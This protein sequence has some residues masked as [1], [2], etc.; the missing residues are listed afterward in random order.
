M[1]P[2]STTADWSAYGDQE[3]GRFGDWVSSAGD[4]NGDGYD[5]I[6]VGTQYYDNGQ[7]DEGRIYLYLGS[8][9]GP[10][11]TPNWT[12]ESDQDYGYMGYR[13]APAG[14][15]NGDGYDDVV[16]GADGYDGGET[17]E[18]RAFVYYGS[19]YGLPATPD[20][21]L[22]IDVANAWFGAKSS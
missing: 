20:S 5:D 13:F 3:S 8:A 10:S 7:V 1:T 4:V 19:E 21:W 2:I 11:E 18:G 15:I 14:D 6:L 16:I 17:D 9:S 12:D 22:E